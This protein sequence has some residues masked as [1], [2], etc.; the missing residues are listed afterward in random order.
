MCAERPPHREG[1]DRCHGARVMTYACLS[2][3]INGGRPLCAQLKE[4]IAALAVTLLVTDRVVS[5]RLNFIN[6]KLYDLLATAHLCIREFRV[7]S[8]SYNSN[9]PYH[10]VAF[11][12]CEEARPSVEAFTLVPNQTMRPENDL[13]W[14]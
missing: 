9:E 8:S 5:S 6:K 7:Y 3:A 1:G 4:E 13:L 2:D 14:L 11:V 12:L 10:P